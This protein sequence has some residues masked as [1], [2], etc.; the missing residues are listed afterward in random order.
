MRHRHAGQHGVEL[1]A[2]PG[3]ALHLGPRSRMP[4]PGRESVSTQQ[5][6]RCRATSSPPL[7]RAESCLIYVSQHTT[8]CCSSTPSPRGQTRLRRPC[9]PT[10]HGTDNPCGGPGRDRFP[11][12]LF[13]RGDPERDQWGC[14]P[15]F[16]R[17]QS[18][19]TAEARAEGSDA[20]PCEL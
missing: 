11:D 20:M 5:G 15:P 12:R 19:H 14:I 17:P 6:D 4:R 3:G 2:L 13:S 18:G 16:I 7:A 8:R 1:C 9:P 10:N